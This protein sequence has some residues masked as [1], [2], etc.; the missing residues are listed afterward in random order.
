MATRS[1]RT[2]F[3]QARHL[4]WRF[5][6]RDTSADHRQSLLGY[7]WLL[8]PPLVNAVVWIFLTGQ[9]VVSVDTG[10]TP[11]PLFVISGTL[12]WTSFNT[13]VMAMLS[14]VSQARGMLAKVNFPQEALVY[15]ALMKAAV[16][17]LIASLLLLPALIYFR[18]PIHPSLLLFPVALAGSLIAGAA[19]GLVLHPIAALYSDIGRG[20]QLILRFGFFIAPVVFPLP[21]RGIARTIMLLNPATPALVSGRAWLSGVGGALPTAFAVV[22]ITSLVVLLLALIV[23]KVTVVHLIERLSS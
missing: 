23:F 2:D 18:V 8:F 9:K 4:A 16:D 12:I 1:L 6:L 11:Y 14:V 20:V 15:A 10:S 21:S 17:T 22:S 3:P 19:V 5:F 7:L 13:S